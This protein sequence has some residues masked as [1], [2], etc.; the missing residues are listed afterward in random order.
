[1]RKYLYLIIITIS[2]FCPVEK[3]DIAKLQ[4]IEAVFVHD[5]VGGVE[6]FTD[7]GDWGRGET[8][9]DALE[10]M[11]FNATRYIYLDT[12]RYLLVSKEKHIIDLKKELKGSVRLGIWN[13][14]DDLYDIVNYLDI[15]DNMPKLKSWKQGDYIPE[16][17]SKI[18]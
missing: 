1:M 3:A 14:D 11:K 2:L 17:K 8:V 15:H 16:Y 10:D 4:P 9:L 12:A 5:I 7:T 18:M 6:I 13:P